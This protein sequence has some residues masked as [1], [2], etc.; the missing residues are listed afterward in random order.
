MWCVKSM[1]NFCKKSPLIE[2]TLYRHLHQELFSRFQPQSNLL[3]HSLHNNWGQVNYFLVKVDHIWAI[4]QVKLGE[5]LTVLVLNS[6]FVGQLWHVRSLGYN[7]DPVIYYAKEYNKNGR[8]C[9]NAKKVCH[10]F[11]DLHHL[12]GSTMQETEWILQSRD[13]DSNIRFVV[14]E[15]SQLGINLHQVRQM[16]PVEWSLTVEADFVSFTHVVCICALLKQFNTVFVVQPEVLG[17]LQIQNM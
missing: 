7:C 6:L 13:K 1:H 12:L 16:R 8:V 5:W 10:L 14:D 3:L 17:W 4:H 15:F 11:V 2:Q 9:L